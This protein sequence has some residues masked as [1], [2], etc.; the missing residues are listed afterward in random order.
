MSE[1]KT[2]ETPILPSSC[3]PIALLE[4]KYESKH[5]SP[6]VILCMILVFCNLFPRLFYLPTSKWRFPATFLVVDYHS[7]VHHRDTANHIYRGG[8]NRLPPPAIVTP[9]GV[10]NFLKD[11]RPLR[12]AA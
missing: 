12:L 1:R 4:P 6:M 10:G 11:V 7:A 2:I 8:N 9:D 5:L 3:P